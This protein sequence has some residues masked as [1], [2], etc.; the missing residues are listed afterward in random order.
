M[1][2]RGSGFAPAGARNCYEVISAWPAY[3]EVM[4]KVRK[5]ILKVR[6]G[7]PSLRGLA[8]ACGPSPSSSPPSSDLIDSLRI[9][10]G[11]KLKLSKAQ[12]EQRHPASPWRF[13]LVRRIVDLADDPDKAIGKWLEFG[14][15][16]GIAE[17]V[18]PGGLLP[19]ITEE[20]TSSIDELQARVQWTTNH[21]SFDS[22]EA[23]SS[24]PTA[25]AHALLASLVDEGHALLFE[26]RD[27]AAKYLGT[28]PVPSPLGDVVKLKPDGSVKHRLIQDLR[29][30][31]V[32]SASVVSERQ[33]L[34]RFIDHARDVALASRGGDQVGVFVIDFQNAFMTLP[35]AKAEQPFNTS[36]APHVVHRS[37]QALYQNEPSSG[38]F[39]VW[40]V[41]GFGGHSNPLTYSRVATFAARSGQAL[42]LNNPSGSD[43][44]EGRLQLYVDDPVVTLRGSESQQEA[45]IDLLLLWWLCLGIPLAWA[46][47]DFVSGLLPHEWIGVKFWS[48]SPSTCTMSLP[49]SF[50]E[51]LLEVARRFTDR[52]SRTTSLKDAH[53][54][55]GK[56]GR[57][58]QV[59]PCTK[60]FVMQLFAGLA[61]SLRASRVGLREA[62]PRKV[63]KRRYRLAAS[64]IVSLLQGHPF[65]LEHTVDI[66]PTIIDH[67]IARVEFDA[68][69]WGGGFVYYEGKEVL[70][71][72]AIAWS[73]DS[74]RHLG[75]VPDI[76]KWQSFWELALFSSYWSPFPKQL[77][78][79]PI[80]S[81]VWP[82]SRSR[83]RQISL[84][85][86]DSRR[87]Q[88]RQVWGNCGKGLFLLRLLL[89]ML[90]YCE[91]KRG[92][93]FFGDNTASLQIA[94]SGKA[95]AEM[96]A[97][98]R[99]LFVR[100]ARHDWQYSV[101]HLPSESNVLA[102]TLSRLH[103]PGPRPGFPVE[104]VGAAEVRLQ[105]LE[106]IWSV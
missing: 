8:R 44:A 101:A 79:L 60:P 49:T 94:L 29:A 3:R 4:A 33:V 52:T 34:P 20:R 68:S 35:L 85:M 47:G 22:L 26:S 21:P 32:N 43:L 74:A 27:D 50:L 9:Q 56:A 19:L 38:K 67:Q 59:I 88:S 71:Y 105:P 91:L 1:V 64:W 92:L 73:A 106:S 42:L 12:V 10:V 11:R 93:V 90:R 28:D 7:S 31:A 54:L 97:L 72:G 103:Q 100:R 48:H 78:V 13:Q 104:L 40:R 36:V 96:G 70:E 76:P 5:V 14:T 62:P 30:S 41:L 45:T 75:I 25:P 53:L 87:F 18:E 23:D 89:V 57:L 98:A 99:E 2:Y 16:V 61:G 15:P 6:A 51:S 69:P 39:L 80:S 83:N 77:L 86:N 84:V 63:A 102:D 24:S 81:T 66:S 37:R 17:T 55:C 95:K 46:K 58:S 82:K 65:P